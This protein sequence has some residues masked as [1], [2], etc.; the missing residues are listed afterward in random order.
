[1]MLLQWL[2]FV[3]AFIVLAESLNKLERTCPL[4]RGLNTHARLVVVLKSLAWLLLAFGAGVALLAPLLL[5]FGWPGGQYQP[6]LQLERPTL[7]DT[8]V[9]VG[10]AVLI[11]RTRVKEG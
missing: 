1:M 3:A 2:H 7:A 5:S 4:E 11:V 8:A 6:L 9:M 10:F